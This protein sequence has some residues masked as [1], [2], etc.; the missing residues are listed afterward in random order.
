VTTVSKPLGDYEAFRNW[1]GKP[2]AWG[3]EGAGWRV[4]FGGGV[5]GG[6]CDVLDEHL[7][8]PHHHYPAAVGCVP[9]LTS[10]AVASHLLALA[11]YC[12]VV[13]KA[14]LTE[15]AVVRPELIN[16][17]K[18][19]P[20]EAIT[21]LR[22]MVPAVDGVAPL[23]IGPS[24]PRE[25]TEYLIDPVRVAGWR[26]RKGAQKPIPH[27]KLLV[28]GEVGVDTYGPDW[29]PDACEVCRFTPQRVWFGSA[30]WTEG[31][32]YHLE[33]GF[34][35][36]DPLLAEQATSFVAEM[37][38]FSEPVDSAC[39]SPEPNLVRVGYDDDALA[40]AAEE[41]CSDDDD[42]SDYY[43]EP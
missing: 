19:F 1:S 40:A 15:E 35:C 17:D 30:N 8:A 33:T 14:P 9:W 42:E 28:L 26:K 16:P 38:A 23:I 5:V 7:A 27:A 39:V 34:V 22:N 4:W 31:A 37:I 36:D 32:R 25:A 29:A 18:A 3:P 6:L 20:N 21:E 43:Y 24:T 13:D 41:Y 10:R 11:S 2:R 12:V